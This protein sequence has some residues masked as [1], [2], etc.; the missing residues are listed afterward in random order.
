MDAN[1][2]GH[3]AFQY[4]SPAERREAGEGG[5]QRVS[6]ALSVIPGG[7]RSAE[8]RDPGASGRSRACG[9]KIVAGVDAM[10]GD[11]LE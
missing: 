10:I 5:K 11:P 6:C 4:G 8:T 1:P 3:R 2:A 7:A 9:L